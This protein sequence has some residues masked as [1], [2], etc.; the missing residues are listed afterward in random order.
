M[1]S[2][3]VF[4]WLV[5]IRPSHLVYQSGD[6]CYLEPY[7]PCRFARQFGYDQL[8]VGNPN[9]N[10]AFM[11]SLIDGARAWRYFVTSYTEARLCMS[12][13]TANLLMTLGFYQWYKTSN[14][15]PTRFNINSFSLKWISQRMKQKVTAKGEGKRVR[16]LGIPEFI[17]TACWNLLLMKTFVKL[18]HL[19]L[20]H[21]TIQEFFMI[22]TSQREL[23]MICIVMVNSMLKALTH[24]H[25]S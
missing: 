1:L 19:E 6:I 8:Y 14:S 12:L 22:K 10:L 3:G 21:K 18:Y 9:I 11:G 15:T 25:I 2:R 16:V 23:L 17:A 13:R 4:E 7:V 20:Y 24:T 5:S